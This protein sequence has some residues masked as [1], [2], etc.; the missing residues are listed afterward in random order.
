MT[1]RKFYVSF[2]ALLHALARN[3]VSEVDLG[4]GLFFFEASRLYVMGTGRCRDMIPKELEQAFGNDT[5]GGRKALEA[6]RR[7]VRRADQ[8][9]TIA[10][11]GGGKPSRTGARVSDLLV[12]NGY[13]SISGSLKSITS[14]D[15]AIACEQA[16]LDLVVVHNFSVLER[17]D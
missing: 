7:S 5:E 16:G 14:P 9:G 15:I 8:L 17:K 1:K 11:Q 10:W 4:D 6:V 2:T 12:K 13:T 3:L